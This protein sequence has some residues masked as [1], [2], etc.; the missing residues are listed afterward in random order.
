MMEHVES[1]A[2]AARDI[3]EHRSDPSESPAPDVDDDVSQLV[4]VSAMTLF[5]G[6]AHS[7]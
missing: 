6:N 1:A 7:H 2:S 4:P 5:G 3:S